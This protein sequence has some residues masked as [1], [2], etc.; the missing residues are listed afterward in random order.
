VD[1]ESLEKIIE[2][3]RF[4]PSGGNRQPLRYVVVPTPDRVGEIRSMTIEALVSQAKKNERDI[5][6][7]QESG[8][9]LSP[10]DQI[11]QLY[12]AMW[13]ELGEFHKQGIDKLF[14]DAT[15]LV[16]CHVDPLT[17]TTA[18]VDAGIAAMQMILMAEALGVG[19]CLCAFLC[20]AIESSVEIRKALQIPDGHLVPFSF[21]AGYPDVTYLTL[22]SRNPAQVHWL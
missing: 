8:E 3:G 22:V 1:R 14:Y 19:T 13:Q 21:M 18:G 17:T 20:V 7:K 9:P 10:D 15:S 4:A 5:R 12:A 2:A 11:R 6:K 16:I